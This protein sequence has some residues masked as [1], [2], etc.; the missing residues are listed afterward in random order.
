MKKLLATTGQTSNSETNCSYIQDQTGMLIEHIEEN[1]YNLKYH[2]IY[3]TIQ[4]LQ[5]VGEVS[6][7]LTVR[8]NQ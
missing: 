3:I 1:F 4:I 5:Q 2:L 8:T 7:C 6:T